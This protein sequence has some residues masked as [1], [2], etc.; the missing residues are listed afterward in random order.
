MIYKYPRE[1]YTETGKNGQKTGT[2]YFPG[3]LSYEYDERSAPAHGQLRE[4]FP[5]QHARD[6]GVRAAPHHPHEGPGAPGQAARG[7]RAGAAALSAHDAERRAHRDRLPL[8]HECAPGGRAAVRRRFHALHHRL[9]RHERLSVPRRLSRGHD[10]HGISAFDLGR[11]RLR[12]IHPLRPVPVSEE[13]RLPGR[14]RR[15]G[16]RDGYQ[17]DAGGERGRL[18]TACRPRVFPGGHLEKAGGRPRA[19][20]AVGGGRGRGRQRDHVPVFAAARLC[21]AHRRRSSRRS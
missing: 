17:M 15:H 11:T 3:G 7:G 19:C 12:G 18:R 5:L 14:E 21:K 8:P 9:G 20:G 16:P 6:R 4:D 10:L 2:G 13:L 1:C